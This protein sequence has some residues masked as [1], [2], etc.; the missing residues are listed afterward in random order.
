MLEFIAG[1]LVLLVGAG[2]LLALLVALPLLVVG[3]LLKLLVGLLL[4]PFR[5][6]AVIFGLLLGL[7]GL[8]FK[9]GFILLSAV[10]VCGLF[11]GGLLSLALAPLLLLAVGV[12]LLVRLLRSGSPV[13]PAG[14]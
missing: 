11:A 12:W 8:L 4:L 9:L 3:G 13:A 1:S 14:A 5:L 7:F 10:V 2:L 6:L